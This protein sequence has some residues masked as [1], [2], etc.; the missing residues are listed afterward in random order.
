MSIDEQH[1]AF[2]KLRGAPA[3]ARPPVPVPVPVQ[4]PA[5]P[6]PIDPDELPLLAEQTPEER[7][8]MEAL[9]GR[10]GQAWLG[11]LPGVP[12]GPIQ[13]QAAPASAA[14]Q[15]VEATPGAYVPPRPP[16]LNG[17]TTTPAA[18]VAT[19]SSLAGRPFTIG[20]VSAAASPSLTGP[21]DRPT[22]SV[23]S[24]RRVPGL[25]PPA[26]ARFAW[27]ASFLWWPS[28]ACSSIGA[29]R[30]STGSRLGLRPTHVTNRPSGP[31]GPGRSLFR[32]QTQ[33]LDLRRPERT[34]ILRLTQ[35]RDGQTARRA[36]YVHRAQ[37]RSGFRQLVQ[38]SDQG[39]SDPAGWPR[40]RRTGGRPRIGQGGPGS[41]V[42]A[43]GGRGRALTSAPPTSAAADP[44]RRPASGGQ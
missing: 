30:A 43:D 19:G 44:R 42:R 40:T 17:G 20:G 8:L 34:P 12:S 37:G 21:R 6:R 16:G 5:T 10:N 22:C 7:A 15:P 3:D 27:P 36:G 24:P 33:G 31:E 14:A 13:A 39:R 23:R 25:L 1:V 18:P 38:G 41:G 2:P 28:P 26:P 4:V 29:G 32:H 11:R 9:L 35:E